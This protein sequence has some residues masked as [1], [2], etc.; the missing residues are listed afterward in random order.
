[1]QPTSILFPVFVQIGLTFFLQFWM[2]IARVNAVRRGEVRVSDIALG[3]R[4]WPARTTQI[5]NAYHNQLEL[6]LLFYAVVAFALITQRVDLALVVMAWLF[7]ALR[8]WHALIHT[9]HNRVSTR[10]YVFLAG[11]FVLL[12]MWAYFAVEILTGGAS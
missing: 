1:M 8:L 6:P 11:A 12:A 7:V 9:T 2:G 5:S 3:Q 4:A 10:F